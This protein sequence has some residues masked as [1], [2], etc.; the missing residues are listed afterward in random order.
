MFHHLGSVRKIEQCIAAT[1]G[2]KFPLGPFVSGLTFCAFLILEEFLHT[3]LSDRHFPADHHHD[4]HDN[5]N[6]HDNAHSHS[7]SDNPH[8]EYSL[9]CETAPLLLPPPIPSPSATPLQSITHPILMQEPSH[10]GLATTSSH[11]DPRRSTV[12]KTC[13]R[14]ESLTISHPD[15]PPAEQ[16]CT[17]IKTY[18]SQTFTLEH[19]HHHHHHHDKEHVTEHMH[20]SLLSSNI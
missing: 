12:S 6:L 5:Q 16:R 2:T 1:S 4:S 10:S 15:Q 13:C 20:G 9:D 7:Y 8:E 14:D 11:H 3:Q 19:H 17:M 18:R